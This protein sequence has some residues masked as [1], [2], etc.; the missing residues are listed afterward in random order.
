[1]K[2]RPASPK[3]RNA[4]RTKAGILAAAQDAFSKH[5]YSHTGIRDIAATAGVTSPMVL[6]YFG[7][8]AGLFEAALIDAM[9]TEKVFHA[10]ESGF[11]ERLIEAFTNADLDIKPPSM[12]ALSAGDP[13]A[14][15]IVSR[16]TAEH[17]I[18]PLGAWLGPPDAN[19]RAL[20]ITI[21]AIG[22]VLFTRQFQLAPAHSSAA[23]KAAAWFART[24]QNIVDES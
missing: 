8:K 24:L 15:E 17:V 18:K 7:S 16:V 22:F 19:A 12:I 3:R 5:G 4:P 10:G 9:R 13:D 21:L 2:P 14:R 6:R 23:K 11:G 1:M 20:Q